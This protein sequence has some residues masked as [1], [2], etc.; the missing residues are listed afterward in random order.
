MEQGNQTGQQKYD[1]LIG[2][3]VDNKEQIFRVTTMLEQQGTKIDRIYNTLIGNGSTTSIVARILLAEQTQKEAS[4][5]RKQMSENIEKLGS[6]VINLEKQANDD[7]RTILE[8]KEGQEEISED[9]KVNTKTV[10]AWRN[11]AVGI[12]IGAGLGTSII[13]YLLQQLI[14][15]GAAP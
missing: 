10:E 14:S 3:V 7:H 13:I 6:C 4:A 1:Q 5:E 2:Q 15:T 11:R 8:L 9:L 12:G